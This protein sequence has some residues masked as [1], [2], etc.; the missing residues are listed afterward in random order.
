MGSGKDNLVLS[1]KRAK[2]VV[3]YLSSSGISK[4]RLSYKG[5]GESKPVAENSSDENR[6]LN[7]RIEMRV[8]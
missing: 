8:L 6:Q 4:S 5:Y 7:R 3:D 1:E 2:A